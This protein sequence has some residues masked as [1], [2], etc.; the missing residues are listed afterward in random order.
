MTFYPELYRG[1]I[2]TSRIRL[3]RNVLG[4]PFKLTEKASFK[5]L[6]KKINRAL[7]KCG[8]FNLFYAENMS[9]A[10]LEAL[11]ER[12]LI[13]QNL[14]ENKECG[15]VL[16][17]DDEKVSVMIGEEDCIREQ[18]FMRGLNLMEAY[19]RL[20]AIDDEISKNIDV[21]YSERYG[22]L[23]ACATNLGT[24]LRSSV[25]MFL[26]A[27]T[28]SGKMSELIDE[29]SKVGLAV[30]GAYGEGSA[31]EGYIYQISN[32]RTL[33]VEEREVIRAV[34][35]TVEKICELERSESEKLYGKRK[36][37]TLDKASKSFGLLTNAV[38]LSYQELLE[39]VSYVKIGA[40]LGLTSI[41]D[42]EAIDDLI[43]SARP[44]I[45]CEQYGKVLS[46]T[47][48]KILRAQAVKRVLLKLKE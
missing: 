45:L 32:E 19:K 1:I 38:M 44:A 10:G 28:E 33:G 23:T 27:L 37:E 29:A 35:D 21:A 24:G 31:A 18:C 41:N 16:I 43:V 20:D 17:S 2:V 9:S 46:P 47:D 36:I 40:M 34:T 48:E 6:V 5:E 14:I 30:R 42:V 8:T 26:P 22:Y 25:M 4:Y 11:K 12:H 3:A 39:H 15:A 7:V 13:S